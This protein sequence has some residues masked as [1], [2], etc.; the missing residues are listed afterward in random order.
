MAAAEAVAADK[1]TDEQ[2]A[3]VTEAAAAKTLATKNAAAATLAAKNAAAE[4][5][6]LAANAKTTLATTL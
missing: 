4:A 1:R 2:K 6:T 5:K 3:L